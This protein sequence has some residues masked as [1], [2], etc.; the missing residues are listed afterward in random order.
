MAHMPLGYN[1]L[2]VTVG[3]IG[4]PVF[5]FSLI[6]P[7][8]R[9]TAAHRLTLRSDAPQPKGRRPIWI[10]ALSVGEVA[11]AEPLVDGLRRALPGHPLVFSTATL[12]GMQT[13]RKLFAD[14]VD[15]LFYSPYD[16]LFAVLRIVRRVDPAL[17]LLVETDIWPN[18][19]SALRR[20]HV[21]VL[22]VNARLSRQTYRGYRLLGR[23]A[24]RVLSG[25]SHIGAQ[26]QRD[27]RRFAD[28]LGGVEQIEVTGN[29]KFDRTAPLDP[30]ATGR[31]LRLHW[32]IDPAQ[33]VILL[34]STHEGEETTGFALLERLRAAGHAPLLIVAPRDPNRA[35]VVV[36]QARGR[37]LATM[38]VTRIDQT[39]SAG[40]ATV[41]VVAALGLL[42]PLYA[43]AD[44]AFVGGS[45]V[46]EGGHNP[47]EP[48]A[49]G[50]PILFGPDMSDFAAIAAQLM[51]AGGAWRVADGEQWYTACH[52]LIAQPSVRKEMGHRAL[53]VFQSNKGA[54]QRTLAMVQQALPPGEERKS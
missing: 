43:L 47:L 10:H 52:R 15:G 33:V 19:I 1:L 50:T 16:V 46:A 28:L 24:R 2:W 12:T 51:A 38:T 9:A 40:A 48:A 7:K 36:R 8:R 31:A 32:G 30:E 3:W 35:E 29:I 26:S 22:L 45:L 6:R 4:L 41:L 53:Q 44:I 18:F 27:A 20:R 5:L 21:P 39:L 11:S 34:G 23:F 54:V 13:A 37:G 25:F 14:K 49:C 42:Q 17:V